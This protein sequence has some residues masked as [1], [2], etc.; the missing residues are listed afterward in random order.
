MEATG[1]EEAK[2]AHTAK[3]V[4]HSFDVTYGDDTICVDAKSF[5]DLKEA[6]SESFDLDA[7]LLVIK[8]VSAGK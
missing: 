2:E 4:E 5:D 1:I 6:I 7:S 3:T 8:T